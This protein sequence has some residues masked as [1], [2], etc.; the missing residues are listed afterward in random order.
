MFRSG[1]LAL[2]LALWMIAGTLPLAAQD[3]ALLDECVRLLPTNRP[4]PDGAD[5]PSLRFVAPTSS[6]VIGTAVLLT[7]E[8]RNFDIPTEGRHW[9]LW[10]NGQLQGMVYQPD[11]IIDLEPGEYVICASLG[12]TDHADIGMP[13][14]L[15]LTVQAAAPGAA[16]TLPVSREAAVVQAEPALG[17]G[18]IVLLV[19][20]ALA[21]AFGGW[22]MGARM[23]KR[24]TIARPPKG[25]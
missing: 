19:V 23:G 13:A 14:G 15:R 3:D 16:P 9:H 24:K 6:Q 20:G 10:V 18:Q 17:V 21:A 12:N 5:A 8:T 7:I 4:I 25:D 22:W 2:L 11:A 1:W